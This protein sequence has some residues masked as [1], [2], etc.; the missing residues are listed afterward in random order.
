MC[1]RAGVGWPTAGTCKTLDECG[2]S[3]VVEYSPATGCT[4]TSSFRLGA[5]VMGDGKDCAASG[6]PVVVA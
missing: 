1:L 4:G 2:A 3:L 5:S 6:A